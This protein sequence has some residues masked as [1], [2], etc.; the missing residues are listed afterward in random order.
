M[1]DKRKDLKNPYEGKK[2]K[3]WNKPTKPFRNKWK[4]KLAKSDKGSY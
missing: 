1:N 2:I 3:A 4:R